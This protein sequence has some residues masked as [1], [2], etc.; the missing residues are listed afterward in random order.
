MTQKELILFSLRVLVRRKE[1]RILMRRR[2]DRGMDWYDPATES[3][4]TVWYD[5]VAEYR[6]MQKEQELERYKQY[7]VTPNS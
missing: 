4:Q 2:D 7:V 6:R 3:T 1:Q 5:P